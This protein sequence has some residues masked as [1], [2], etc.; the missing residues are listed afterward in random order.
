MTDDPKNRVY[1]LSGKGAKDLDKLVAKVPR[2]GLVAENGCSVMYAGSASD[3]KRRLQKSW[4]SLVGGV[5][6]SWRE[7]VKEILSYFTERTPGSWLEDRGA[8]ILWR[9]WS[10]PVNE[11]TTKDK[12]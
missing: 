12:A 2:I 5:N 6:M 9:F 1:I 10:Q 3:T 7:P 8:S 11:Q 4:T